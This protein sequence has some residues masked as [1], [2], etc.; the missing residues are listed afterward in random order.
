MKKEKKELV[1][2]FK[3]VIEDLLDNYEQYTDEE[4]AQIKEIFQKAADLNK[5]L[6]KYDVA[7]ESYW[8]D[9]FA[10][11]GQFFGPYGPMGL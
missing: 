2:K 1:K 6:D 10:A 4:K 11:Y 8:S 5:V 7:K 3:V 9:F